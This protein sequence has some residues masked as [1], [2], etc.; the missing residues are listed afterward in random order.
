MKIPMLAFLGF[1]LLFSLNNLYPQNSKKDKVPVKKNRQEMQ[2]LSKV[3][4]EKGDSIEGINGKRVDKDIYTLFR[5]QKADLATGAF[6]QIQGDVIENYGVTNNISR[7][8]GLL[9]GLIVT[10]NDGE[11]GDEWA[12]FWMRGKRTFR[13]NQPIIL[14]DGYER[15]MSF[16]D[17]SEIKAVTILKDAAATARYGLRGS[18]GIIQVTTQ[19]GEEGKVKI[20]ANIRGGLKQPTTKPDMLDSYDYA[21]LYNEAQRNDGIA[22]D[23]VRYS[24]TYL[25][26]YMNARKGIIEDSK[27]PY[28]Y[29]N[30]DWYKTFTKNVSWQQRYSLSASGG[31]KYAHFFV[32]GGYMNNSGMYNTDKSANTYNT[33]AAHDLMTIRSNVD[34]QANKRL[35]ISLDLSGMLSQRRWPGV[36]GSASGIFQWLAAMPPNAL[37]IMQ[38]DV[39]PGTGLQMLGGNANEK[40]TN[41]IYGMLNRS[42]Y[43][44]WLSRA[45]TATYRMNYDLS[46]ITKGLMARGEVAFDNSYEMVTLRSKTYSVWSI[47][48]DTNGQP[49]Y[50]P[51][52][53]A[54]YYTKSGTDSQMGTGGG[55]FS[56]A[57]RLNYRI[58]LN[59]TRTF[60]DHS[61]YAEAL[62]NERE[63]S[64]DIGN[65]PRVYRSYDGTVSYQYKN[66]YLLDFSL[67][68]MGSEQFLRND[69]FGKFPALSLGWILTQEPFLRDNK[70]LS[71]LKLRG[72]AGETGWDD[73]GGYFLWYQ[74]YYSSGG[75]NFGMTALSVN[76]WQE[77][78]FALPNVTWEKDRQYNI[79]LDARFLQDRIALSVDAYQETNRDIM[80]QPEL[81][82]TMGI[83][84]P[85][86]PIGKIFDKGCELSLSYKDRIGDLQWGISGVFSY[87]QNKILSMGEA[88][89]LFP[90][91]TV[92]GHS[93]DNRFGYVALGFFKDQA[94]IDNSPKQTFTTQVS[95]GDIKYKDMN[96]DNIINSYDQTYIGNGPDPNMQGG[97]QV[98]LAWKGFDLTVLAT[99]EKGG[100]LQLSGQNVWAF[101][102]QG[103]ASRNWLNRFNPRD[104]STWATATYPRLSLANSGGNTQGS[105]F[106]LISTKQAR[107]KNMELG[108]SFPVKWS[109]QA[110]NKLRLYVN[111]Y[112]WV[113]WQSTKLV[114]VEARD[115]SY[116][117]YP[118]QKILN[119]GVNVTF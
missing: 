29:P 89:K 86:M 107:L 57:R 16:L 109:K 34:I 94:D 112:D 27:D 68:I 114:D 22:D 62:F 49:L 8:T 12:S 74:Q 31:N 111:A 5:T 85:D 20:W 47:N 23:K 118:I 98:N 93:L 76:G 115:G 21:T 87:N 101:Y 43:T 51:D 88:T 116:Y 61:L 11:P 46:F 71:F 18:C 45:M 117:L 113:T 81:P 35:S 99:A 1:F 91:Q 19:R 59:Y 97:L 26:K 52:S 82:Y 40:Y 110:I 42:G 95:P 83:R 65:L 13:S 17:P 69:R 37:P 54:K 33:N 75:T 72:S 119:F 50:S 3:T 103:G 30:I 28:L 104:E 32:S 7:L 77:G 38:K 90:Y 41:N 102:Q 63:I 53:I 70:I 15:D 92:T 96:G 84:F 39:D 14:I 66:R 4:E 64:N 108:Y 106:W 78:Q 9:P 48:T 105:T 10:Q 67:G 6:S 80:R 58:G 73:T 60:G 56:T 100:S 44:L 25:D 2:A 79:G 55:S 24:Q 36:N